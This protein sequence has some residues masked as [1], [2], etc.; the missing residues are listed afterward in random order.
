MVLNIFKSQ[1]LPAIAYLSLH[2]GSG[3]NIGSHT[4]PQYSARKV[5]MRWP[6]NLVSHHVLW[7]VLKLYPDRRWTGIVCNEKVLVFLTPNK[8]YT[9][10]STPVVSA[11]IRHVQI[12]DTSSTLQGI[13][14]STVSS[15]GLY[16][17]FRMRF[18][19]TICWTGIAK[20]P[21]Y[22][23]TGHVQ[24]MCGYES[25]ADSSSKHSGSLKKSYPPRNNK[26]SSALS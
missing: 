16:L 5:H 15:T 8:S 19:A 10:L 3:M 6:G 4:A 21:I 24:R 13:H 2:P 7:Y 14:Q 23:P 18:A 20:R 25:T 17:R 22:L 12:I 1:R 26:A 9:K 11:K